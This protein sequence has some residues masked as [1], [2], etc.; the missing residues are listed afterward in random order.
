MRKNSIRKRTLHSAMKPN[1]IA[2]AGGGGR[3]ALIVL[4]AALLAALAT[5]VCI[6]YAKLRGVYREQ[7]AIT[8]PE[9]QVTIV[10]PPARQGF[11][12][13]KPPLAPETVV[14]LFG[15]R[16]GANLAEIDFAGL[17]AR[18]LAEQHAIKDLSIR[19]QPTS[20]LVRAGAPRAYEDFIHVTI[21]A[22]V[23]DPVAILSH[24]GDTA[25]RTVV[26]NFGEFSTVTP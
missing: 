10:V 24:A 18:I 20:R 4:G 12:E 1:A 13:T 3:K 5:G 15:L 25:L 19:L 26:G 16:R 2:R 23:R 11:G 6:G 8:D 9:R 22:R 21:T 17:R 7:F 14:A